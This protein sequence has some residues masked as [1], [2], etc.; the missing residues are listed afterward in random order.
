MVFLRAF[1]VGGAICVI[2]QLLIDRTKLT[3]ARILV[4]FVVTGVALGAAGVFEPLER[5]AGAGVTV[6]IIGF[7]ALLAEGTRK[8]V[9]ETGLAGVLTGPLTAGAGG[10][11]AAVLS[12]LVMS[13]LVRPRGK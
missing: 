6:P 13:V 12:G 1:A 7:G 9:A 10:I 3:P 8:A 11:M 4:L 5:F 2:G